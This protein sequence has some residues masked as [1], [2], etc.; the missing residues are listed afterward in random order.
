MMRYNTPE[1]RLK[2]KTLD[3]AVEITKLLVSNCRIIR[4]SEKS[5]CLNLEALEKILTKIGINYSD[6]YQQESNRAYHEMRFQASFAAIALRI[7]G[8]H[9]NL[10][11]PDIKYE[12][13]ILEYFE[14]NRLNLDLL[15]LAWK[16]QSISTNILTIPSFLPS[17][18]MISIQMQNFLEHGWGG[19]DVYSAP[20]RYME[21]WKSLLYL[22]ANHKF[23]PASFIEIGAAAGD[24]LLNAIDMFGED[25]RYIASDI[26]P[27]D[28]IVNGSQMKEYRF[29]GIGEPTSHIQKLIQQDIPFITANV[30]DL[31]DME[32]LFQNAVEPCV[33]C[34]NVLF[35][36]F[37]Q[38]SIIE[39]IQNLLR[40][41]PK[42][43]I[44]GGGVP[45]LEQKVFDNHWVPG[46]HIYVFE[47]LPDHSFELLSHT[48]DGL[49]KAQ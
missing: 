9:P 27:I 37:T 13:Q 17:Q 18:G 8:L 48:V 28:E 16:R 21:L 43:L 11:F 3:T 12:T 6:L 14:E 5:N 7:L 39:G 49:V 22:K 33:L 29:S 31:T 20:N 35:P 30:F 24:N 34:L 45:F 46:W 2:S 38:N 10:R 25:L 23:Q 42:Y 41:N 47:I 36:H 40:Q 44:I 19:V 26:L 4:P 32:K 15:Y 1:K